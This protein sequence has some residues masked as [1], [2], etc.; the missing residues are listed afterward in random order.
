MPPPLQVD[1]VFIRKVAELFRYV[2]YLRH[3]QQVDL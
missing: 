1:N 2:G 3:Q